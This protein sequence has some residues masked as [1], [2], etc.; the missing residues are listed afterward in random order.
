MNG[1]LAGL[2]GITASA[3][4]M[5]PL[6]AVMIGALAGLG[7]VWVTMLL[8]KCRIDDAVGAVPVHLLG[9]IWGTLAVALFADPARLGTGLGRWDQFLVQAL[10]VAAAGAWA[11]GVGFSVLWLINRRWP[12]RVPPEDEQI[13]LNV[14]EHGASTEILDLFGEMDQ[15]RQ[16]ND[17]TTPVAVEPHTEIG[18]I[19][20]QYNRVLARFNAETR[21]LRNATSAL[22]EKTEILE[23]NQ[24]ITAA[25]NEAESVDDAI[26]IAL[27]RVCAH[28]GWP[29]GHAYILEDGAADKLV[30][31][32]LWH[33][34]DEQRFAAFQRVSEATNFAHGE[35]LPGRVLASGK[36]AW[37]VDVTK[38]PNFPRARVAERIGIKGAFA[39]PILVGADV[40]AVLEFFS[41]E[42][43]EPD[44]PLLEV[45][46]QIGIQLGRVIERKRAEEARARAE[47]RLRDAIENV[48]DGFSTYDANDRLVICNSKFQEIYGYSDADVKPGTR[49]GR[50]IE[51]DMERGIVSV[52]NEGM[53]TARRRNDNL[54]KSSGTFDLPLTDGRWIQIRDGRTSDGGTVSIHAD[55][56]ERKSAE[57]LQRIILESIPLPLSVV[58]KS[59]GIFLYCN[60][61]HAAL[62]GHPREDIVGMHA[63]DA[64]WDPGDRDRF[65]ELLDKQGRVDEFEVERK[66]ADGNPYWVLVS[67]R[68][69]TFQGE[70]SI[71]SAQTAITER[72]HLEAGLAA[73]T[74]KMR[75]V[76][77]H[78]SGGIFMIDKDLKLQLFN[79]KFYHWHDIPKKL[80]REGASIIPVLEYRAKR[81]DYGEGNPKK[82]LKKRIAEYQDGKAR[83]ADYYGSG[84]RIL[85]TTRMPMAGGGTVGVLIDITERK[86]AEEMMK[87]AKEDAEALSQSKSDF[88]AVVS[89]EVRTPMNGVLGMARLL[90]DTSLDEDQRKKTEN[91]VTS[92]DQLLTILNDLLDVSKLE[93]GKLDLEVIPF[94][95]MRIM[96]D[97]VA[98]MATRAEEKGLAFNTAVDPDIPDSL[99]GDPNRLRQI[100]LNLLS[101]AIKFTSEGSIT[102]ALDVI[103][104]DKGTVTLSFSVS[105]TGEGISRE[106]RDKIF[107]AYT[108]ESADVARKYGGTGLGL[109]ICRQL[110]GLMGGEITLESTL[111]QGSTFR[112]TAPFGLAEPGE[113]AAAPDGTTEDEHVRPLKLL[114]VEDNEINRDVAL[115]MLKK[116]GHYVTLAVNGK[117]ALKMVRG[118]DFDA[119]LMDRHM[120][121][122]NGI[123]A[124]RRIRRMKGPLSKIPIIGVTAAATKQELDACLASGMDACVTKPID[125]NDLAAALSRVT[126]DKRSEAIKTAAPERDADVAAQSPD[127]VL[128]PEQLQT[129][130]SDI[131]DEAAKGLVVEF[132]RMAPELIDTLLRA[133][134]DGDKELFQRTA[135]SLKSSAQI[136]GFERLAGRCLEL[137]K[138]CLDGAFD[139][140]RMRTDGLGDCLVETVAA[141]EDESWME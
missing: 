56:T 92:G 41:V 1:S 31:T 86:R 125:S 140:A 115:S 103:A 70:E 106:A 58:R 26:Q 84:G 73:E 69:I 22:D 114:L 36:P 28:T 112:L 129:L 108:Q 16:S 128:D 100:L 94:R 130:R 34:N 122:M 54:G 33:V 111:G 19:A 7:S 88:V 102:L 25:A 71:L 91:I 89:H 105:N 49:L 85:E 64:Y 136:V 82:L 53:E 35:G 137:E 83:R 132:G 127:R 43:A 116:R 68:P 39:F 97:T 124:T 138:S 5:T 117:E 30:P 76:L 66:D 38:D 72:K 20:A 47:A 75:M 133:A 32:T 67:S 95:P 135:H 131:G 118:Q 74:E 8:E 78:M 79:D 37:I 81:G 109:V 77:E 61:P 17:F 44:E 6:A 51:L 59:D 119:V 98:V 107:L 93:A 45:M 52:D 121:V 101:N 63:L 10:G 80:A 4:I 14:S 87:K 65:I 9:G 110:A 134:G 120:P 113:A 60:E 123:E 15:H 139:Q 2:V 50:L 96:E 48:S 3:N 27:D 99:M 12:L 13:G 24:V 40:A 57:E 126:G 18:Q 11:F 55:I 23:L 42:A 46:E 90:L 141:L 104:E 29:V 21:K 62:A